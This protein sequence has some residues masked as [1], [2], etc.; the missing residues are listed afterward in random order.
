LDLSC[1][2]TLHQWLDSSESQET[3]RSSALSTC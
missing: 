2:E 1:R 3:L